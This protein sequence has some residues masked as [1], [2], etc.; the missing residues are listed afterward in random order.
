MSI[1]RK[2]N[3]IFFE[4][5]LRKLFQ[6]VQNA[7]FLSINKIYSDFSKELRAILFGTL[8]TF[9]DNTILFTIMKQTFLVLIP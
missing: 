1:C 3:Y 7:D 4:K 8:L 6:N 2:P 5:F 9:E